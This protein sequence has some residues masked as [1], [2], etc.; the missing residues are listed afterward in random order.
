LL[1]AV[2]D[3]NAAAAA[4]ASAAA[5]PACSVASVAEQGRGLSTQAY[6]H[7]LETSHHM[8]MKLDNGKV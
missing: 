7:S 2:V 5:P 4:A 6:T 8:F 3:F 1:Q